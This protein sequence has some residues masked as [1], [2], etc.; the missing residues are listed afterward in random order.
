MKSFERL[1]AQQ[2]SPAEVLVFLALSVALFLVIALLLYVILITMLRPG[3]LKQI[4]L[5]RVLL[6]NGEQLRT[7]LGDYTLVLA[8]SLLLSLTLLAK[9]DLVEQIANYETNSLDKEQINALFDA[10]PPSELESRLAHETLEEIVQPILKAGRV[11]EAGILVKSVVPLIKRDNPQWLTAR[12]LVIA[13]CLL[14]LLYLAWLAR[15]RFRTLRER[16]DSAPDYSSTFR[17]LITLGLCVG[18]LLASALPLAEGHEH[19]L[20]NSALAAIAHESGTPGNS[21]IGDAITTELLKQ[22]RIVQ[23]V[24]ARTTRSVEEKTHTAAELGVEFEDHVRSS[25]RSEV[26]LHDELASLQSTVTILRE[27]ILQLNVDGK[28]LGDRVAALESEGSR[29]EGRLAKVETSTARGARELERL[30]SENIRLGARLSAL[31][32]GS[33]EQAK[34]FVAVEKVANGAA[35]CCQ[36]RENQMVQL[37]QRQRED[38]NRIAEEGQARRDALHDLNTELSEI[39]SRLEDLSRCCTVD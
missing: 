20:G 35:E 28:E 26:M 9:H 34:R 13:S 5:R 12:K 22:R 32:V 2:N 14:A 39:R 24:I 3:L 29:S 4:P 7:N 18:L 36:T 27:Q 6:P 15:R 21:A 33:A 10:E 38:S 19:L 8:T 17:S 1:L 37:T 30:K 31:E 23:I 25:R 11:E 16:P